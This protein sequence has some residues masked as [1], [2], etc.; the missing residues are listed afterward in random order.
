MKSNSFTTVILTPDEGYF[1][2]Q[3]DDSI[4]IE[5]RI[6]CS[7]VALGKNDN[8]DNWKEITIEEGEALKAEIEK[9]R[10]KNKE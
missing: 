2:T 10:E 1:L 6:V 7:Q 9:S 3:S 5:N 4:N 8:A